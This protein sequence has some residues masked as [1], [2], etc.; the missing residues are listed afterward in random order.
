MIDKQSRFKSWDGSIG[1]I[2]KQG[3][4]FKGDGL[5]IKMLGLDHPYIVSKYARL[6]RV[7]P[8]LNHSLKPTNKL[9][10]IVSKKVSKSAVKRNRI[11]R[12]VYEWAR[13]NSSS[14]PADMMIL[15]FIHREDFCRVPYSVLD[16]AL[17]DLF[18]KTL[19]K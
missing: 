3:S 4:S 6:V 9:A 19:E 12:R 2:L 8:K 17:G 13:L 18:L 1:I 7:R 11:R 15:L 10:V 14:L 5:S 16:K